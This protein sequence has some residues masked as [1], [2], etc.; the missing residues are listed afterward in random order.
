MAASAISP[1][2]LAMRLHSLGNSQLLQCLQSATTHRSCDL[3]S[4]RGSLTILPR[5]VHCST[6]VNRRPQEL[7]VN[8]GSTILAAIEEVE[9]SINRYAPTI[10]SGN[11][12]HARHTRVNFALKRRLKAV[13]LEK[14][15]NRLLDLASG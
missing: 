7:L 9:T 15:H 12:W 14:F 2:A 8:Y 5:L 13:L 1:A 10:P 11:L 3:W 6:S 4:R